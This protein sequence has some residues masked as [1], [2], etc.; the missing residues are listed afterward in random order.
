MRSFFL[1]FLLVFPTVLDAAG[2]DDRV[3][4]AEL[5]SVRVICDVN[6]GDAALLLRRL[7]LIDDTY[8]QLLDAGVAPTIVVAFRGGASRFVTRGIAHVA[9]EE[10]ETKK[11]IQDG[12]ISSR[13][14]VSGSNSV[15][16]PPA[17]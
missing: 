1:L 6:V 3:A 15:P 2:L 11:R 16:L 8:T 14:T 13:K 7:E 5:K 4:L 12:S 9:T 17:R 10:V